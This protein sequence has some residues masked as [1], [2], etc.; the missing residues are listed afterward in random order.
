VIRFVTASVQ[1][2]VVIRVTFGN[3][4]TNIIIHYYRFVKQTKQSDVD[5]NIVVRP[6]TDADASMRGQE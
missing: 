3:L 5:V 1:D 4:S 2:L 6:D